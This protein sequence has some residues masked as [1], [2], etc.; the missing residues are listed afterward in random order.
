MTLPPLVAKDPA[1]GIKALARVFG[2]VRQISDQIVDYTRWWDAQNREAFESDGPRVVAIGDSMSL[3]IGASSP[4]SGY[5]GLVRNQLSAADGRPWQMINL[6]SWGDKIQ[7]GVDRQLPALAMIPTPEVV[8]VCI[9]SNDMVWGINLSKIT[10]GMKTIIRE[11]PGPAHISLLIGTSPR[12]IVANRSLIKAAERA[13]H[14]T[15]NPWFKWRGN[16]ATDRFHPN[17]AGYRIM[18]GAFC[19]SLGIAEPVPPND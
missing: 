9:G 4:D 11:V 8:L 6:G 3:G 5:L 14:P 16:Q 13:G 2:G 12:N 10:R 7:D 15:V 18:A 19:R 1:A 17:D